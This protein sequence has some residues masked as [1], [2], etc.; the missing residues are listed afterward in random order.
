MDKELVRRDL[1]RS[2]GEAQALIEE[3]RVVVKGI[4][5]PKPSTMVAR[6]TAIVLES[7]ERRWVSRGAHKLLA[8]LETF[9]VKVDARRA[10][11]VGSS[12]GGFTEVLLDSGAMTVVSLD[13]GRGQLHER[14]RSD[15]RVTSMERTDVRDADPHTLGAP[16]DVVV[17]DLSF[18]S[19]CS[20]AGALA[21]LARDDADFVL[22]IKPQFESERGKVGKGG[23]VRDPSV[24]EDAVAKVVACLSAA[25][26]Q[27]QRIIESPL[28]GADGNVE[29]LLWARMDRPPVSIEVSE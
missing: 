4:P 20:V 9:P 17:A 24:R 8:A 25:G 18:I 6:D 10:I 22:L 2:R 26:I 5:T 23:I 28:Q 3:G 12:T 11:D 15:G 19:L 14:L 27:A 16:F 1:A 29:Y 7:D 21:R 13:V